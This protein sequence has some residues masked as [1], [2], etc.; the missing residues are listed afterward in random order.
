MAFF[1]IVKDYQVLI[2]SAAAIGST[3]YIVHHNRSIAS[4]KSAVDVVQAINKDPLMQEGLKV[5]R[6]HHNASDHDISLLAE[7]PENDE[8]RDDRA[9]VFYVLNQYEH[10]AVGIKNKTY[11]ETIVKQS[12]YGTIVNLERECR[13]LISRARAKENRDSIWAELE[14]LAKKWNNNPLVCKK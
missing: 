14:W 4:K 5:I 1:D 8:I 7:N 11:D 6:A 2:S 9:K 3:F 10:L 12:S 13:S